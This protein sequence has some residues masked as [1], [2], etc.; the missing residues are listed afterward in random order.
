MLHKNR[1]EKLEIKFLKTCKPVMPNGEVPVVDI[2]NLMLMLMFHLSYF[3][4]SCLFACATT[5]WGE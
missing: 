5:V 3:A 4:C 2:V 1:A